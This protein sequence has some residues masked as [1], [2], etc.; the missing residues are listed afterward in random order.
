MD[1]EIIKQ[2]RY[3][4]EKSVSTIIEL[5]DCSLVLADDINEFLEQTESY[6]E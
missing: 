3:L 4:L 6:N 1:R 2:A 5:G